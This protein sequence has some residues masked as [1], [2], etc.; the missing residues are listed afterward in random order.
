MIPK[1]SIIIPIYNSSAFLSNTIKSVLQ[2]NY[3]NYEIILINDGSTDNSLDICYHFAEKYKEVIRVIDQKNCGVTMA[4]RAGIEQSKGEFILFL[5]SDDTLPQQA[6][7]LLSENANGV[8]VVIGFDD[9]PHTIP[10]KNP[11]ILTQKKLIN[12]FLTRKIN[13]D[14]AAKLWKRTCFTPEC[15][16]TSPS[17]KLG[18]DFIMNIKLSLNINKA[19]LIYKNTYNYIQHS[20]QTTQNFNYNLEYEKKLYRHLIKALGNNAD[21]YKKNLLRYKLKRLKMLARFKFD[22]NSN[23]S[24][25]KSTCLQSLKYLLSFEDYIYI[26]T[27]K[28]K[29]ICSFILQKTASLKRKFLG[30]YH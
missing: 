7:S 28:N 1:I 9:A 18:E 24:F 11:Q 14:I 27:Y 13:P 19:K 21:I 5:D 30:I 6:L 26:L 10:H 2:Q 8:D 12:S 4:R 3:H 15:M 20:Q 23:D 25:I 17:I 29:R 16:N 22:Y